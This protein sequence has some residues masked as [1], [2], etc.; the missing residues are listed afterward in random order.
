MSE[1]PTIGAF[2]KKAREPENQQAI[3]PENQEAIKPE[4]VNLCAKVPK[5]HRQH[6]AAESKRKGLSMTEVMIRALEAEFGLPE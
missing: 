5:A 1:K 4:M 3:E 2:I 6:W